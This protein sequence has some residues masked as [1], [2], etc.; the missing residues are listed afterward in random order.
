MVKNLPKPRCGT[1]S[2]I[3]L[4]AEYSRNDGDCTSCRL[5]WDEVDE[6]TAVLYEGYEEYVCIP[7]DPG[8]T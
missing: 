6:A 7:G 4:Q 5:K 8:K 3:I 1:C 2:R